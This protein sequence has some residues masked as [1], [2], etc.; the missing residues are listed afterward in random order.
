MAGAQRRD[1]PHPHAHLLPRQPERGRKPRGE[2][3]PGHLDPDQKGLRC[4]H[5]G[6]ERGSRHAQPCGGGKAVA[7]PGAGHRVRFLHGKRII[8]VY[9]KKSHSHCK[10]HRDHSQTIKRTEYKAYGAKYLTENSQ[11]QRQRTS[12]TQWIRERFRH[13]TKIRPFLDTMRKQQYSEKDTQRQQKKRKSIF[14][15]I[16]K[17]N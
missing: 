16:S 17:R 5:Q 4:T 14:L 12:Y 11:P 6:A 13:D 10:D 15:E 3:L 8:P 2:R 9:H 7:T 1:A